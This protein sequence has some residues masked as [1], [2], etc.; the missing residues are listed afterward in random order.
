MSQQAGKQ[1]KRRAKQLAWR[2][3][4]ILEKKDGPQHP[5]G[6]ALQGAFLAKPGRQNE[7]RW[8]RHHLQAIRQVHI[9]VVI[10]VVHVTFARVTDCNFQFFFFGLVLLLTSFGLLGLIAFITLPYAFCFR[11]RDSV[12]LGTERGE[13]RILARYSTANCY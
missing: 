9:V 7:T 5:D 8:Y 13:E 3:K 4:N 10:V 11:P 2:A 12:F 6:G 1:K